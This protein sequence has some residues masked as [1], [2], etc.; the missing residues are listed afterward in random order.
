MEDSPFV[1]LSDATD[2]LGT[3]GDLKKWLERIP[4]DQPINGFLK[5][6]FGGWKIDLPLCY[7][8]KNAN[9]LVVP[10]LYY[11]WEMPPELDQEFGEFVS[12]KNTIAN[13]GMNDADGEDIYG[14]E[15]WKWVKEHNEKTH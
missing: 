5:G 13:K 10:I 6:D 2:T 7:Q 3:V 9:H 12:C 1:K 14:K 11:P 4:D 15:L 8:E